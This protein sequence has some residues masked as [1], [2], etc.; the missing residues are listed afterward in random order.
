[1]LLAQSRGPLLALGVTIFGWTISESLLH[2]GGK[3]VY[4]SKLCI[5]LLLIFS[6]GVSLFIAYPGF[7]KSRFIG[8]EID[9]LELWGSALLQAKSA[10]CFGHGLN[11]DTRIILSSGKKR[12]HH[13]SVYIETLFFGGIAGLLL[14]TVLVGLAIRQAFTRPGELQKFLLTCMLVFGALCIM[15]DGNTLIR[16]PKPV[17]IFFWFPIALVAAYELSGNLL[18]DE[19][20]ATTGVGDE[21]SAPK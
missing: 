21:V 12:V 14:L 20:Q 9:R 2:K 10:P 19:R 13:H 5:A 1:M 16:H 11:A 15:T 6:V 8:R 18:G 17:W 7:F 3:Y 4:R